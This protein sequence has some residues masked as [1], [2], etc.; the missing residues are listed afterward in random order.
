[1]PFDRDVL[2]LLKTILI[3]SA[4]LQGGNQPKNLQ[5]AE[6]ALKRIDP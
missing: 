1:M 6:A 4:S 3:F 2:S 5:A